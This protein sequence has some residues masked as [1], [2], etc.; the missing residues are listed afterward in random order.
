M[1][2]IL[3]ALAIIGSACTSAEAQNAVNSKFAQNYPVCLI[4]GA[5]RICNTE[6]EQKSQRTEIGRTAGNETFGMQNTYV[7]MGYGTGG[8]ARFR[9]SRIRISYDK[10]GAVYEGKETMTNDGVRRNKQ[11]NFNTNNGAYN[12][13]PNNGGSL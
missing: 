1:K 8:N 6:A 13:P 10:P 3:I 4:N 11:R 9:N 7:H 5:Y 2:K 12:L